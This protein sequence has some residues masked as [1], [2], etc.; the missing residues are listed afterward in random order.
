M[1]KSLDC[2]PDEVLQLILTHLPPATTIAVQRTSKRFVDVVNEPLLWK[3][4][5]RSSFRWWDQ[6]WHFPENLR[7]ASF[8]DWKGL[9]ANRF[10]ASRQTNRALDKIVADEIGRLDGIQAI[11]AVG[12]DAKDTLLDL[13]WNSSSSPNHLAQR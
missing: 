12:Y 4:Y 11:L 5:C 8:F 3:A 1:A 6:R 2:L 7:D 10:S 13:Y 9:F